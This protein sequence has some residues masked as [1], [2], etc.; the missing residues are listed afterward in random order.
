M[1]G[2]GET[3]TDSGVGIED[4]LAR[5]WAPYRSAYIAENGT[6][7]DAGASDGG[8]KSDDPFEHLPEK[9][10]EEGLI[11]ARGAEVFCILNL[12]PYNPGHMMVLP[13]RKV[14]SYEDLTDNETAEMAEFTKKAIRVL[15]RVSNPN[16]LNVGMNLGKSSGGSV[17]GHLHQHI[18]PRWQGDTSFMTVLTG[19]KVLVQLLG[20]TRQLLAQAWKEI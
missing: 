7:G 6:S 17:P 9:S 20:E 2:N 14:A 1:G 4:G 13:Y 16:A 15:R 18:V 12:Y 11:V 8:A 10:D 3:V 19:S 5:L